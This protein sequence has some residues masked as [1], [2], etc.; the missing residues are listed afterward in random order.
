MGKRTLTGLGIFLATVLFIVSRY[1][2]IY[3]F[4]VF[5]MAISFI[6]CFEILKLYDS[7]PR[8][9]SKMY[10]YLSFS[11]VYLIYLAYLFADNYAQAIVYQLF[12]F[13]IYFIVSFVFELIYLAKNRA[14]E[15]P[16]EDLLLS[17]KRLMTTM[18]YP[19]TLLGTFYGIN[20]FNL[21]KATI[22][23][24]LAFGIS[25]FTDVFAYLVGMAFHKGKFASQISPKKSVSGAIGGIFGGLLFAGATLGLCYFANLFNPFTALTDA[26][27]KIV[28]FF[29]LSGVL[30]SLMTEFGDLV[31]SSIKRVYGVKD[32]GK[33]F[34]GH[35]GM[36]DRVDGL[37]FCSAIIYVLAMLFLF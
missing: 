32:Y 15:I 5:V 18:L 6:A 14:E 12:L 25:M 2:S 4:D 34:P 8:K 33:L 7:S 26:T 13:A 29:V 16:N 31:A 36:M 27:Y 21:D 1:L 19:I 28:L 3:F 11:Y 30:G 20:S 24:G 23:I 9:S 37:M 35:G 22:I 10:I 17:T